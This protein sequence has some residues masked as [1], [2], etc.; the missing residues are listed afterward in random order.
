MSIGQSQSR[1]PRYHHPRKIWLLLEC[2]H[3]LHPARDLPPRKTLRCPSSEV[4]APG[5]PAAKADISTWGEIRI[6]A[7]VG[8]RCLFA[9]RQPVEDDGSQ[10]SVGNALGVAEAVVGAAQAEGRKRW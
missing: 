5:W 4:G 7:M 1:R 6:E 9:A 2:S 3:R 10:A 8:R